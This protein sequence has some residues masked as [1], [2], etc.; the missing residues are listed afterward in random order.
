M[1]DACPSPAG[2]QR[3]SESVSKISGPDSTEVRT[4][5]PDGLLDRTAPSYPFAFADRFGGAAASLG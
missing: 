3:P 2:K 1:H 5:V 4:P